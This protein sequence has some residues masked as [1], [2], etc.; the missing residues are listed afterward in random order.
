MKKVILIASLALIGAGCTTTEQ[1]YGKGA[2]I[3]GTVGGIVGHQSGH[4]AEGV[5]IGAAAGTALAHIFKPQSKQVVVQPQ[6]TV[7]VHRQKTVTVQEQVP[8]HT[9]VNTRKYYIDPQSGRRVYIK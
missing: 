5:A 7:T 1:H 9:E 8:V 4:T 6:E 3:G 2:V